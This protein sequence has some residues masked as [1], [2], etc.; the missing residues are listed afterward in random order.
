MVG[1]QTQEERLVSRREAARIAGV[2][3]NTIR[4][5]ERTGRLTPHKQGGGDVYI[6]V[7][8]LEGVVSERVDQAGDSDEARVAALT[9]ENKMLRDDLNRLEERYDR[10]LNTVLRLA[11]SEEEQK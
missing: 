11:G 4:L 5:W 9:A 1:A 2:H 6:S 7:S 3:Y 8:E 10:L